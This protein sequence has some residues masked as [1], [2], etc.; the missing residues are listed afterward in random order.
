MPAIIQELASAIGFHKQDDIQTALV[1]ADCWHLSQTSTAIGQSIGVTESNADDIGKGH[2]FGTQLF[3]SHRDANWQWDARLSSQNAAMLAVFGMGTFSKAAAGDGFKYT[4]LPLDESVTYE[5]PSTTV[6][7]A[8]R[9]GA[10]DIFDTALV[11]MVCS[12][13]NIR[14]QEGPGRDNATMSSQW[15]G[16]G[17][18]VNPSTITIPA[19][20]TENL[21]NAGGA[22]S[23]TINS[24]NYLTN[25]RF[26]SLDFAYNNNP[27]LDSGFYPGSGSQDGFN[28]RGRL[29]RGKRQIGLSFVV[30]CE[31]DSN[32]LDNALAQTEGTAVITVDG[33]TIGAGP[34]KHQLKITLH[35]IVFRPVVF[36][37]SGGYVTV[38]VE[39]EVLK[40]SS[41]G[42]VTVEVTTTQDG[43]GAAAV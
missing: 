18:V 41:N 4:C 13:F 29:R 17:L 32:E 9:Q 28:I 36:G 11:G 3:K 7:Q 16:S 40:H 20:T 31:D 26:K 37:E 5:L 42:V 33:D 27:A 21:L 25:K 15:V 1:A 6:V 14:L 12:Q 24:V 34:T 35:R 2:E 19:T 8:I 10:S 38:A 39:C 23:I 43:I 30:E 22:T